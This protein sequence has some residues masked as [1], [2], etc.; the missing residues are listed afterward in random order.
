MIRIFKTMIPILT[1]LF[2]CLT[3]LSPV[4][5]D[6][7]KSE[8]QLPEVKE[9]FELGME[10]LWPTSRDRQI[11]TAAL[12]I[13]KRHSY[14]DDLLISIYSG[15]T[16]NYAWGHLIQKDLH[17]QETEYSDSAFGIG[18]LFHI[19]WAPVSLDNLTLSMD[20]NGG[21]IFHNKEFPAG[22]ALYN[23]IWRIGPSIQYTLEDKNALIFGFRFVHVS[24]GQSTTRDNPAY[25]AMGVSLH[26][27]RYF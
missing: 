25:N 24:N 13:L 6:T 5:A 18:P 27:S 12:N 26:V 8:K 4:Y 3:V 17:D 2:L 16:V 7:G 9:P 21:I 22:G 10:Y 14:Y 11:Q 19:R 20:A 15:L 23:F 1:I